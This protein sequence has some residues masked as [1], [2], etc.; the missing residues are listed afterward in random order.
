MDDLKRLVKAEQEA[1]FRI[2]LKE[3]E[4]YS[5]NSNGIFFD[6]SKISKQAFIKMREYMDFCKKTRDTFKA[7][8]EE[9]RQV[10]ELF[11][12]KGS[13]PLEA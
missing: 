8:E 11:S 1:I 6:V 3:K 4:D 13:W 12:Q 10:Q 2:L 7:R 9:E 5:E